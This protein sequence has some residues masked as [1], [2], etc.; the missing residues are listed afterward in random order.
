[1]R[2]I[3]LFAILVLLCAC[4]N[5]AK[6]DSSNGKEVDEEIQNIVINPLTAKGKTDK[7]YAE[8]EVVGSKF[9]DF[10][11]VIEGNFVTKRFV[12]KNVGKT[13]MVIIDSQ[14]SCG[15]TVPSYEEGVISPGDTTSILVRFDTKKRF[16]PQEKSV[17]IY[18]NTVP[19]ETIFTLTGTVNKLQS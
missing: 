15:C 10:G 18:T 6:S 13:P 16:G 14:A 17:S 19:N 9:Y 2:S 8:L 5:K 1:M 12:I 7:A 4:D 3:F 11:T